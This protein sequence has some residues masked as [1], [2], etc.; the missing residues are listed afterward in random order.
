MRKSSSRNKANRAKLEMPPH[1][2]STR[3][4]PHNNQEQAKQLGRPL[5]RIEKKLSREKKD[6]IPV[7]KA[8]ADIFTK[9]DAGI[10]SQFE[11]CSS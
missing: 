3:N 6:G 8:A 11:N 9:M 2:S 5:S 4:I 10:V 7:N 1:S